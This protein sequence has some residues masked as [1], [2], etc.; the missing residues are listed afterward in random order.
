MEIDYNRGFHMLYEVAASKVSHQVIIEVPGKQK[1]SIF[2]QE[3]VEAVGLY[4]G[5]RAVSDASVPHA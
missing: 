3:M 2:F 5:R 1:R 4:I